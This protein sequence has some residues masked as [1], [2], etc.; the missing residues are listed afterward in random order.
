MIE[1]VLFKNSN[2]MKS[3]TQP[4]YVL[5]GKQAIELYKSS[6]ENL[7]VADD[8]KFNVGAYTNVRAF[9]A[10]KNRWNDFVII[11]RKEYAKLA[12]HIQSNKSSFS[13]IQF[14]DTLKKSFAFQ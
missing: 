1:V 3:T 8:L 2:T 4:T 12:K 14:L 11:T 10:D 5:F 7:V 6:I 13:F 9:I